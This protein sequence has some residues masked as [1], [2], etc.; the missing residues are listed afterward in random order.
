VTA[1]SVSVP[2]GLLERIDPF[3]DEH[4]YTGRSEAVGE[5]SRNPL[6]EFEDRRLEDRDPTAVVTV[7]FDHGTTS[8]EGRMTGLRHDYEGIVVADFH[9]HVGS[10][11]CM[12]PFVP[13][14]QLATAS[15]FVGRV[16]ATRDTPSVDCSVMPV[17]GVGP[18]PAA[19]E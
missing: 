19:E 6:G 17:D 15:T 14:G 9:G 2:E 5:A 13:E 10:H 3:A 18:M 16:R 1:V 8:V 7:T 11:Y 12:E 4:G